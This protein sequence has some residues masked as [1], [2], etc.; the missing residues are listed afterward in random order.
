MLKG[1]AARLASSTA[2]LSKTFSS[3]ESKKSK[4][5][6]K[7]ESK[8]D[9]EIVETAKSE[10]TDTTASSKKASVISEV[11]SKT[12]SNAYLEDFTDSEPIYEEI[13]ERIT[14]SG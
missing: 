10:S 6:K 14:T 2:A 1:L 7:K 11:D 5:E 8:G 13:P 9:S 3:K 12:P 4:S